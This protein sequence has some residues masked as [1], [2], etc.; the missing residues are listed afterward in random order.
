MDRTNHTLLE[1]WHIGSVYLPAVILLAVVVR[2]VM[3]FIKACERPASS[4][5][6]GTVFQLFR[7]GGVR[8]PRDETKWALVPDFWHPFILGF[9]ELLAYPVLLKTHAWSFIGAWLGFKALAQW[10]GWG[11]SRPAYNRFLIGNAIVLLLSF[12]LVRLGL[13]FVDGK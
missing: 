8:S 5:Y 1:D 6:W 13:V 7:G 10:K 2:F 12:L 3:C 4:P 11:E 9:L